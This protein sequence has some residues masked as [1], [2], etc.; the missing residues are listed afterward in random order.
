MF[1]EEH[2]E[3][4]VSYHSLGVTQHSLGDFLS[5]LESEMRA[6][7]I[8]FKVFGEE[9]SETARSVRDIKI[10]EDALAAKAK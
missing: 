7:D 2:S 1:G 3:T 9:H 5:D 6:L 8:R 10:I 4:A